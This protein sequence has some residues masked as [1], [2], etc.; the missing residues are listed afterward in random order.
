MVP[1]NWGC[2]GEGVVAISIFE[3]G[4]HQFHFIS[5]VVGSIPGHGTMAN[6]LR[7]WS[8]II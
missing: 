5:V 6:L 7:I 1:Q 4:F 3:S 8:D 2:N